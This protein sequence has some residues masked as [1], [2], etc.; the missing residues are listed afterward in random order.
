MPLL[1]IYSN[2]L[3]NPMLF[4]ELPDAFAHFVIHGV[5]VRRVSRYPSLDT[6]SILNVS[7]VRE[8]QME[9]AAGDNR[10]IYKWFGSLDPSVWLAAFGYKHL[11]LWHEVSISC[12]KAD[13]I[14]ELNKTLELGEEASWTAERLSTV[15]AVSSLYLP[16]CEMVKHM[17]G[18]GFYNDNGMSVQTVPCS[19]FAETV[20]GPPHY[21]W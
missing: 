21:F 11:F 4:F 5:R 18:V 8:L 15:D 12:P 9:E 13:E 1:T 7:E 17:D 10:M 20:T 14:F 3:R 19:S 2:G 16:A 6:K